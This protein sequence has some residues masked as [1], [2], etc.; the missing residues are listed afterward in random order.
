MTVGA[1]EQYVGCGGQLLCIKSSTNY[2]H[3]FSG[4]C[5]VNF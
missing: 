1:N 2:H 4:K 5:K 3:K